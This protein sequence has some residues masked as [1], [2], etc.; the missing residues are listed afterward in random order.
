MHGPA[1]AG[2]GTCVEQPRVG[3]G[4]RQTI[5]HLRHRVEPEPR[6]PANSPIRPGIC[7]SAT[8]CVCIRPDAEEASPAWAALRPASASSCCMAERNRAAAHGARS[9]RSIPRPICN[10]VAENCDGGMRV[11][12][13]REKSRHSSR[14]G[15]PAAVA[16]L[17]GRVRCQLDAPGCPL[18]R[19]LVIGVE[20]ATAPN[21]PC[22]VRGVFNWHDRVLT[23][24][25]HWQR[26]GLSAMEE[27][28]AGLAPII[29]V[30]AADSMQW[31]EEL[32]R[33]T[34]EGRPFS[35]TTDPHASARGRWHDASRIDHLVVAGR[36]KKPGRP[37]K[38]IRFLAVRV[39][40]RSAE[41]RRQ[42]ASRLINEHRKT[43][44]ARL[45]ARMA[46]CGQVLQENYW[47][48]TV[49]ASGNGGRSAGLVADGVEPVVMA[50]PEQRQ[51]MEE[52]GLQCDSLLP[53]ELV[54]RGRDERP[55]F[56]LE[57]AA[58]LG[59]AAVSR[60]A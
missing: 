43:T 34:E 29:A 4:R 35:G 53:G 21:A 33:G 14:D 59:E 8:D 13:T 36:L 10:V 55:V 11:K 31:M 39:E 32:G 54:L 30:R 26:L 48:M 5:L 28:L 58:A 57:A 27:E 46:D 17:P 45:R 15:L 38:A 47:S 49:V 19:E 51:P 16:S 20:V 9:K 1:G 22:R 12:P 6:V 56:R 37:H 42:Q 44:S 7:R 50:A 24:V 52:K 3:T 41:G 23:C 60:A 2:E 25:D 40:L 18:F